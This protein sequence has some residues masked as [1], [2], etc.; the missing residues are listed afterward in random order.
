MLNRKGSSIAFFIL[1]IGAIGLMLLA[2]FVQ[3]GFKNNA[4]ANLEQYKTLD[5]ELLFRQ[6]YVSELLNSMIKEANASYSGEGEFEEKF[7]NSMRAIAERRRT[8]IG[9]NLFLKI[10]SNEYN[11][12]N[13]GSYY[14]EIKDVFVKTNMEKNE[15]TWTFNATKAVR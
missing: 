14:F 9:S 6:K 4:S 7:K 10:L 1:F 12:V 5:E 3:I 11:V 13:N 15:V 2:I 8:D